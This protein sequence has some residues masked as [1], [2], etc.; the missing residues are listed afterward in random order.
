MEHK[1]DT[2]V[3]YNLA[4]KLLFL[5]WTFIPAPSKNNQSLANDFSTF[6]VTKSPR[7]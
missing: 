7:L 5:E 4:N 1:Y 6:F 3:T 2:L